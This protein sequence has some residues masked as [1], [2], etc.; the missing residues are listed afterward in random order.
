MRPGLGKQTRPGRRPT[1]STSAGRRR[2][3]HSSPRPPPLPAKGRRSRRRLQQSTPPAWSTPQRD[4]FMALSSSAAPRSPLQ[5]A[6]VSD[7]R[8]PEIPVPADRFG[9]KS[10]VAGATAEPDSSRCLA[11]RPTGHRQTVGHRLVTQK[12]I[13]NDLTLARHRRRRPSLAK[14]QRASAGK[15]WPGENVDEPSSP[16]FTTGPSAFFSKSRAHGRGHARHPVKLL[17]HFD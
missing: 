9:A 5:V 6:D 16:A 3:G 13:Q 7:G 12:P 17:G 15:A 1:G 14:S 11:L 8:R 10:F 2:G 4:D